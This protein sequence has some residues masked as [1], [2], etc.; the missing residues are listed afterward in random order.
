MW[1]WWEHQSINPRRLHSSIPDWTPLFLFS[2]QFYEYDLHSKLFW[3]QVQEN[4]IL[5]KVGARGVFVML[6]AILHV[7]LSP[8][9]YVW[10]FIRPGQVATVTKQEAAPSTRTRQV[11]PRREGNI[12]GGNGGSGQDELRNRRAGSGR[13]EGEARPGERW[14]SFVLDVNCLLPHFH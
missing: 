4:R 14:E 12:L 5:P 2:E 8:L 11:P 7:L 1:P 10:N 9:T 3:F 6:S 13:A